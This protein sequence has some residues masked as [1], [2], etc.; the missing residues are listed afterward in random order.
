M[1]QIQNFHDFIFED[2]QPLEHLWIS[3]QFLC[4]N[5][6]NIITHFYIY[7]KPGIRI[8]QS[9]LGLSLAW[10]DHARLI[11]AM[12]T[13]RIE[14]CSKLA[15]MRFQTTSIAASGKAETCYHP[16]QVS[17]V[18]SHVAVHI[19][20]S[21]WCKPKFCQGNFEDESFMDGQSTA[22]TSKITCTSL[23]NLYVYGNL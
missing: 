8:S 5:T 16:L 12:H 9:I 10:P 2:H 15:W 1:S 17:N 4:S 19:L 18:R 14:K 21:D 22:K 13:E 23:E 3:C 20:L 7:I 11:G 6:H